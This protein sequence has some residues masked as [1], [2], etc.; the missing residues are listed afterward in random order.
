[1]RKKVNIIN[2]NQPLYS[3]YLD[4]NVGKVKQ[5]LD[6]LVYTEPLIH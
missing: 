4:F 5:V 1:M 3:P 2:G 6:R